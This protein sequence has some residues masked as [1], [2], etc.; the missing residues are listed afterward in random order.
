MRVMHPKTAG[1]LAGKIAELK[2]VTVKLDEEE[3]K[4]QG[5]NGAVARMEELRDG[6][7]AWLVA[8]K[9]A[10]LANDAEHVLMSAGNIRVIWNAA[11]FPEGNP[12]ELVWAGA[13]LYARVRYTGKRNMAGLIDDIRDGMYTTKKASPRSG[14]IHGCGFLPGP[15]GKCKPA[16][17]L[18]RHCLFTGGSGVQKVIDDDAELHGPAGEPK[19]VVGS[20]KGLSSIVVERALGNPQ[21]AQLRFAVRAELASRADGADADE[22]M[23]ELDEE[24]EEE[25]TV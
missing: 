11:N 14:N 21:R 23:A 16:E 19:N 8:N 5:K 20:L 3:K 13:K 17:D 1:A 12:I 10:V 6:C 7:L 25:D 24:E 15:D 18:I 22:A 9:P 2:T 4:R